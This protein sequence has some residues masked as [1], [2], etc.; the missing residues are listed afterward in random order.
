[1]LGK[2]THSQK[3][4]HDIDGYYSYITTFWLMKQNLRFIT[5]PDSELVQY[6]S[7]FIVSK[8]YCL[9]SLS[10]VILTQAVTWTVATLLITMSR[11]E[12]EL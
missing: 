11:P 9:H 10:F 3:K 4:L 1:M 5:S 12:S 7:D 8:W 2:N 6:C